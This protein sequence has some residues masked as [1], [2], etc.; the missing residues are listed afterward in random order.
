MLRRVATAHADPAKLGLAAEL[1][2]C[3]PDPDKPVGVSAVMRAGAPIL[4]VEV[5]DAQLVDAARDDDHLRILRALGPRSAILVPLQARGHAIGNISVAL[6]RAGWR[7]GRDDLELIVAIGRHAALAVDNARLL[8]VARAAHAAE[9]EARRQAEHGRR[10]ND[11]LLRL[12][13]HE[14]RTPLTAIL[15]WATLLHGKEAD[16]AFVT[17]ALA[18]IERSA[19]AQVIVIEKILDPFPGPTEAPGPVSLAGLRVLVVDAEVLAATLEAAGAEV[20][21][22]ASAG[23]AI[24]AVDAFAPDLLL[25]DLGMPGEDGFAMLARLRASSSPH[26]GVPAVALTAFPRSSDAQRALRAGFQAHLV[27]PADADL[28]C[29]TLAAA[30]GAQ[31]A[32]GTHGTH[33]AHGTQ[34]ARSAQRAP[35]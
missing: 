23:E 21:V 12:V 28:L 29:A 33:G 34:L 35:P 2:R 16:A 15:G 6:E 5:E 11:A 19:R 27:K 14:L 7:Y 20:R 3:A 18:V 8:A 24:G 30:H 1:F 32:Q 9:Q 31:G 4:Q 17:R 26:A 25:S 22:A 13:S 10:A